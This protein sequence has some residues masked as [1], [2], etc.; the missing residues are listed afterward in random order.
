MYNIILKSRKWLTINCVVNAAWGSIPG[1]YIFQGERI[2]DDYI[3]H[4][5]LGTCMAFQ[6]KSWMASFLFK[7]FLSLFKR[8][9]P[10]GISPSKY[11]LLALNGHGSHVSLE[12]VE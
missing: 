7:E 11:H 2:R 10:S 1:F 9:V 8:S 6:T 4:Y 3:M 12:V 5:K